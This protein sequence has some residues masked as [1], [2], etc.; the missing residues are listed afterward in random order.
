MSLPN[1]GLSPRSVMIL[2]GIIEAIKIV[3]YAHR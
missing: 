1:V 2:P 3:A